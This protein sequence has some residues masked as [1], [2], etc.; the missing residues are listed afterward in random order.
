MYLGYTERLEIVG[1]V[2][3]GL[4]ELHS[5]G[6]CHSALKA[7]NILGN[8]FIFIYLYYYNIIIYKY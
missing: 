4:Q 1:L 7:E 8:L 3:N 2:L 6:I 5:K